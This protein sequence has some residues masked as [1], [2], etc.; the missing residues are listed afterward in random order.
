M[1]IRLPNE[2]SEGAKWDGERA[3]D[4]ELRDRNNPLSGGM[5]SETPIETIGESAGLLAAHCPQCS[6]KLLDSPIGY[7]RSE[8]DM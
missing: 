4:A 6:G 7:C 5:C 2:L 3:P 1:T 8:D